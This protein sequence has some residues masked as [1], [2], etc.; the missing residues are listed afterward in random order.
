[1]KQRIV[2]IFSLGLLYMSAHAQTKS[3]PEF[4][5]ARTKGLLPY[6]EYGPGDDRLG[7]A[8]MTYLDSGILLKVIDSLGSDYIIELTNSLHAFIQKSS[9]VPDTARNHP[10]H[11]L[12]GN[13]KTYRDE[14]FD[15]I[16]IAM[17]ERLPYRGT[18]QVNPN[19]LII[20]L[21]GITS[22]TNWITQVGQLKEVANTWYEQM[23]NG[24]LRVYI[25]LKSSMHW[26][27]SVHY[28]SIG[29]KLD[30]RVKH[31]PDRNL[32]NLF[33]AVD[34]GHG[35]NNSGAAGDM[36]RKLEKALTLDYAL[37]LEKE[38]KKAGIRRVF[39]TRRKD[40]SLSMPERIMMLRDTMPD[41]LLSIH[42]NSSSVDTVKGTSTFYRH[43]GFRPLTQVI[44]NRM[45]QLGLQEFGN[46][47]S[48]NFALSGPTEY[49]NCLVEVAFLSN[50]DDERFIM[51]KKSPEKVARKIREGLT[52]WLRSIPK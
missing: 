12:S 37:A 13:W 29:S 42:F 31:A 48:F 50:P 44:L 30:I 18:M 22:N 14:R 3:A 43:I 51:H 4:F 7:G 23:E 24:M 41:L 10:A 26:G 46:V 8:K 20:D 40:T 5:F 2:L 25:D 45:K 16:V 32:K 52:D 38:L 27:Y 6:V 49:P 36:Y 21:F 17:P 15:H 9:I 1:M 39:M 35:G 19:R 33:V 34:A 28:D 11:Y 47:G